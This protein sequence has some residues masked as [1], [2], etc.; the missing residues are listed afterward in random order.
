M[1]K[2]WKIE[3]NPWKIHGFDMFRPRLLALSGRNLAGGGH[4]GQSTAHRAPDGGGAPTHR[5]AA[6]HGSE[7]GAALPFHEPLEGLK[8]GCDAPGRIREPPKVHEK[9]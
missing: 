9:R 6:V 3:E 1:G 2:R 5:P 4:A 7:G 8:P